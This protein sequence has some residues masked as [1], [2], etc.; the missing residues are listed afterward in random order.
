M[1]ASHRKKIC[2]KKKNNKFRKIK[3]RSLPKSK[4]Q[5]SLKD[6]DLKKSV[7]KSRR[8]SNLKDAD[9]NLNA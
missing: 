2:A 9:S 8:L 3:K 4:E 1:K 5:K 7:P 6:K